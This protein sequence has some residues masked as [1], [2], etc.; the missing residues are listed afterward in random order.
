MYHFC[1]L[2]CVKMNMTH[3]WLILQALA[4]NFHMWGTDSSYFHA[5][6]H[7]FLFMFMLDMN[8]DVF[9]T[10]LYKLNSLIP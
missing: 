10:K 2:A 7:G 6:K 1:P 4:Q 9:I 8:F 3:S 5:I